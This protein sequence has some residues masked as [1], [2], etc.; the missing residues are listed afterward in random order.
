MTFRL[1]ELAIGREWG[2]AFWTYLWDDGATHSLLAW[3]HNEDVKITYCSVLLYTF[4]IDWN[5]EEEEE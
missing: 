3:I 2:I 5:A 4:L 1:L